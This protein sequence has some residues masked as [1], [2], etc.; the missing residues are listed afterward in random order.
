MN[1]IPA[2]T[3]LEI[4]TQAITRNTRTVLAMTRTPL[5][6]VVK[7]DAYGFGAVPVAQAALAGGAEWL[8]VARGSEA[9]ALR[10]AG[11]CAPILVFGMVTP[12]EMTAAVEQEITLNLFNFEMIAALSAQGL[13]L[14]GIRRILDLE[15]QVSELATRVRELEHALAEE[16]LNRPGRRV[17][18]AGSHGDVVS[19]RAGSRAEKANQVVVWRPLRRGSDRT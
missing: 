14:E 19:I 16:L 11:I 2:P 17:F 13:N 3:W 4:D 10:Q 6:A 8:A 15:N 9:L 18:A 12:D 7:A 5:M 1:P